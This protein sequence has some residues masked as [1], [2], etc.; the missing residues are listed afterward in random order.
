MTLSQRGGKEEDVPAGQEDG[1]PDSSGLLQPRG[2]QVGGG[3]EERRAGQGCQQ[4]ASK[5]PGGWAASG[6]LL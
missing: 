1:R 3:R 5:S 2:R 4:R 6:S